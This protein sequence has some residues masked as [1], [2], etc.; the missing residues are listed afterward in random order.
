MKFNMEVAGA[1]WATIIS[2][3]VSAALVLLVL[4]RTSESYKLHIKKLRLDGFWF[5]GSWKSA[6]PPDCSLSC[7]IFPTLSFSPA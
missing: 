5:A 7:T 3:A 1:A 4:T 2:Q 6:C